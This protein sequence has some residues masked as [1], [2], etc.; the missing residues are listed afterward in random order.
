MSKCYRTNH[1]KEKAV[2]KMVAKLDLKTAHV[3]G[4]IGLKFVA[5]HLCLLL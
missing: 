4:H 5:M 1:G 3:T 2:Q